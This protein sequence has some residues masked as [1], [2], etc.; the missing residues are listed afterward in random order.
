[1]IIV[2]LTSGLGNQMFQYA[3]GRFLSEKY[4]TLLKL[5][6][7]DFELPREYRKYGL[8]CFNIWEHIASPYEI[9]AFKKRELKQTSRIL[10]SLFTR[11]IPYQ[12]D[13][14]IPFKGIVFKEPHFHFDS[15][16][17]KVPNNTYLEGYWQSEKYFGEINDIIQRE[18]TVKYAQDSKNQYISDLINKTNSVSLHIRRGDYIRNPIIAAL[19][20]ICELDYYDRAINYIADKVSQPHFFIFSDEP[21]WVT[22]NFSLKFPA[23]VIDYNGPSRNYEDLRLMSLCRH[24]IIANSS[25]SWWG[26]WLN[27]N[28]EKI[29]IT[30][31]K[32]FGELDC[33]T[34]DL[35]PDGWLR[36]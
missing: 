13:P 32:W 28:P 24:Q 9:A 18:F 27:A 23:T 11:L 17:F 31:V 8:H 14:N 19:H 33:D 12:L 36:M 25:F 21:R 35:I 22:E 20:N 2:K 16:F 4:S 3:A 30:P 10:S 1:M 34:K 6:I 5:D 29:V 15:N 26:A 7:S